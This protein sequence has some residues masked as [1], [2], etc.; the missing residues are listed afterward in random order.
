METLRYVVLVN[1]L[2]A[3]LSVAYYV[4]L[5]RE[6][7]FGANPADAV[8]YCGGVVC[9]SATGTSRLATATGAGCYAAHCAGR[10]SKSAAQPG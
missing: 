10:C 1:G 2:L 3:A 9:R 5:R 7:F 8:A 6:T 4:L